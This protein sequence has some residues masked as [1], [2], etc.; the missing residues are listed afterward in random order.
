VPTPHVRMFAKAF[1]AVMEELGKK[2]P[3][4]GAGPAPPGPA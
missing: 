4:Q 1:P 2:E 3:A